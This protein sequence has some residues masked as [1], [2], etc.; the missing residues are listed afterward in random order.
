MRA[1]V[2]LVLI[3]VAIAGPAWANSPALAPAVLSGHGSGRAS[4]YPEQNKIITW[5]DKTHV[6]WLDSDAGGFWVRG[7]TLDRAS[8]A[9]GPV[10]TL[11]PAQDNHGGPV[12]TIDRAGYLHVVYYPHHAPLR[13]QRS[14]RPNDLSAWE[15]VVEFGKELSYPVLV[16][17]PDG[18]LILTA[19][20]GHNAKE[21][22][23]KEG[24]RMEQELWRKP[25]GG[26]WEFSGVL[27]QPRF[28]GYSAYGAAF[29][30]DA[31]GRLHLSARIYEI[32]GRSGEKPLNTVGYMVS[33]DQGRS[34][35]SASGQPL[36]L[37]V[38]AESIDRVAANAGSPDRPPLNSGPL[39]V[40]R[41]GVPHLIYSENADGVSHLYLATPA[42]GGGW[43]RRD[44]RSALPADKA[45]W[46]I[47]LGMGGGLSFSEE[48][49]AT[50][51]AVILNPPP[52][53]R[54][55]LKA[56]AHPTTEIV[57]FW[58]DDNLQTFQSEIVSVE[59]AQQA[60][61]LPNL[62]RPTGH[63]RVPS[64]PGIIYTAGPA[65]GG[66]HDLELNNE[67]RWQPVKTGD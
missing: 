30:W 4:A 49:R 11:G 60:H 58:S 1:F 26:A 25:A 18:T 48:G 31:K 67:V 54:D 41:A 27:I 57:R 24:M 22:E 5:E 52:A 3:F 45:G 44:L 2:S 14:S 20:R 29:A 39:G 56:W 65:G 7:R 50:L 23:P 8:G 13:Y 61:W 59:D 43:T 15:P 36:T 66:L 62:E 38:N 47:E 35:R 51:V 12:L 10:I 64:S 53:E 63:N 42:P 55:P 16:C 40:D 33:D 37:P 6:V 9:W 34:W 17:A 19:R 21:G 32:T 28:P 46:Q